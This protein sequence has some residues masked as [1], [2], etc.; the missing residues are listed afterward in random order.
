VTLAIGQIADEYS[1]HIGSLRVLV[2]IIKEQ[3]QG[4]KQ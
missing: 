2:Q 4:G 1:E 3:L